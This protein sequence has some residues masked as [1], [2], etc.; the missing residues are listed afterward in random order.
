MKDVARQANVSIATVSAVVN[1]S[2]YVS[3][4]L[5]AR[6][7]A[8]IQ[9][10]GYRPNALARSLKKNRSRILS[11]MVKDVTNPF[12][13]EMISGA[14]LA[15]SEAGYGLILYTTGD[16]MRREQSG[17]RSMLEY[18]VDGMLLAIVEE[19][20]RSILDVVRKEGI[21]VVLINRRPEDYEGIYVGVDNEAAGRIATEHLI[22][23][24]HKEIAFIG[25]KPDVMT[26]RNREKGYRRAMAENGLPVPE[27]L[28]RFCEYSDEKAYRAYQKLIAGGKIP[29]AIFSANDLMSFGAVRALLEAGLRIPEDVAVVG[30]D[31]IAFSGSFRVPLTTVHIPKYDIGKAGAEL[32]IRMVESRS[33][34][35]LEPILLRPRLVVRQS[36]GASRPQT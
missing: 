11:L 24:G 27:R 28:I 32:L 14:E 21:P 20:N 13:P 23:L 1:N 25:A 17:L 30:C 6:V 34:V 29:G 9:E 2:A 3:E 16:D 5:L 8:A 26:S 33:S 7:T 15:A 12:Y 4:E 36:C 19:K 18:R 10:L 35:G 31:D 22:S